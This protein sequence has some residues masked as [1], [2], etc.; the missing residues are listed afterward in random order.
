MVI[1][2]YLRFCFSDKSIIVIRKMRCLYAVKYRR[3][4][5]YQ[6]RPNQDIKTPV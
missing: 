1:F 2:G 4:E 5:M 3:K 6:P